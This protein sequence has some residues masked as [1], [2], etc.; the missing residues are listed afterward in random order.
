M[1]F[2]LSWRIRLSMISFEVI[3][4][5]MSSRN[6]CKRGKN[7]VKLKTGGIPKVDL[8]LVR[9]LSAKYRPDCYRRDK[10]VKFG[11]ELP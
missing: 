8:I 2:L 11:S 4:V 6:R 10:S 3:H 1:S 7:N 9:S 5:L